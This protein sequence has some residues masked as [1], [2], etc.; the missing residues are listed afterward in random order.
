MRP[1]RIFLLI[2]VS[3]L[4][5]LAGVVRPPDGP[6]TPA[7][8]ATGCADV[9]GDGIVHLIDGVMVANY[10]GTAAGSAPAQV[11]INKTGANIDLADVV[12]IASALDTTTGCQ[13]SGLANFNLSGGALA[14][15]ANG[16]V[17]T[18]GDPVQTTRTVT[19]NNFD[20]S[21]QLTST[22]G[23]GIAGFQTRLHWDEAL[24]DFVPNT[25]GRNEAWQENTGLTTA[26]NQVLG[27]ADDGAGNEA[28]VELMAQ[29]I[30][31]PNNTF[32]GPIAQFEFACHANGTANVTLETTS[33]HTSL[34]AK[35]N[36]QYL[37]TTANATITCGMP[38]LPAVDLGALTPPAPTKIAF[39]SDR[40]GNSEI[41]VMNEDG[42]GQT[43]LTNHPAQD[44]EPSWSPD[45]S[46]IAF[47]SDRDGDNEIFVMNVDGGGLKQLTDNAF[48]ELDA[49]WSPGGAQIAFISNSDGEFDVYKMNADGTAVTQLT[50]V[51]AAD[52]DPSWS[53]LGNRIAFTSTRDGGDGDIFV[54]DVDGTDQTAV[55]ANSSVEGEAE[56]SPTASRLA[57]HRTA[58]LTRDIIAMNAD[59]LDE[60]NLTPPT[61]SDQDSS[62]SWSPDGSTLAF[63]S[64]RDG[65]PG[66]TAEIYVMNSDGTAPTRL[67]TRIGTE[68]GNA[69][70]AWQPNPVADSSTP[71]PDVTYAGD[72]PSDASEFSM[73]VASGDVNGDGVDDLIIGDPVTNSLDGQLSVVYGSTALGTGAPA[74][75]DLF[76]AKPNVVITAPDGGANE[77]LGT[78]LAAGDV[79]G[80]GIDDIVATGNHSG[81]GRAFVIFGQNDWP[82][83]IDLLSPPGAVEVRTI[84]AVDSADSMVAVAVG[85]VGGPDAK[86][87]IVLGANSADG[88]ANGR[89]RAGEAYVIYGSASLR[90]TATM[91][92]SAA[93]YTVIG[94]DPLDRL[95]WFVGVSGSISSDSTNELYLGAL[96]ADGG[97]APVP[98]RDAAGEAYAIFG[99]ITG[100]P[101]TQDLSSTPADVIVVGGDVNDQLFAAGGGATNKVLGAISANAA[102]PANTEA[103]SG[104]LFLKQGP[105]SSGTVLDAGSSSST[106][107]VFGADAG[108]QLSPNAP[109]DLNNDGQQDIIISALTGDGPGFPP[110]PRADAGEANV[111]Y[112]AAGSLTTGTIDFGAAPPYV[113]PSQRIY[114]AAAGDHFGYRQTSGDLNGDG[115]ADLIVAAPDAEHGARTNPGKVYVFLSDSPTL[116]LDAVPGGDV[117]TTRNVHSGETFSVTYRIE[118]VPALVG[119]SSFDVQL[120][121]NNTFLEGL[122]VTPGGFFNVSGVGYN[123]S[124]QSIGA[125]TARL[126]CAYAGPAPVPGPAGQGDLITLTF[127]ARSTAVSS[128]SI[129]TTSA[130]LLEPAKGT[131][132]ASPGLPVATLSVELIDSVAGGGAGCDDTAASGCPAED[133]N[134]NGARGIAPGSIIVA[135]TAAHVLRRIEVE[136]V[137]EPTSFR[138]A[139]DGTAGF[140]DG[141]GTTA[142]FR[143]PSGIDIDSQGNLYVA[144]ACNHRIRK[145]TPAGL[146]TTVAGGAN[147]AVA[148]GCANGGYAGDT[149]P[150]LVAELDTPRDV[151]VDG[152][153]HLYI[154]DTGNCRIARVDANT[155]EITTIAGIPEDCGFADGLVGVT[156]GSAQFAQPEGVALTPFIS[157]ARPS[158][159]LVGDTGNDRIRKVLG[160][161][162][163]TVASG[164]QEPRGIAVDATGRVFFANSGAD[165][166]ATTDNLV[167]RIDLDG[168]VTT[169]AGGGP[170][171]TEPCAALQQTLDTTSD[172]IL[173]NG[174]FAVTDEFVK[175]IFSAADAQPPGTVRPSPCT[176]GGNNSGD[177][178]A[179][180]APLLALAFLGTRRW[181]KLRV[182]R[183]RDD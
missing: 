120:S 152:A 94:K 68:F 22:A 138:L 31:E 83:T 151:A 15:D 96:L 92:A 114:G 112:G 99:P 179:M 52:S 173:A 38:N 44:A 19:Q 134:L 143:E 50:N 176:S 98:A 30:S 181:R 6:S 140:V 160:G 86:A 74:T 115:K 46:K 17:T 71:A 36:T 49:S 174:I 8:A 3:L 97:E 124:Q 37:P 135:D 91:S 175:Q 78:G 132:F 177:T 136:D 178:A 58:G 25:A 84:T 147:G 123:C 60:T 42:S 155:G 48:S 180:A 150:A 137:D 70:P 13:A 130:T 29:H 110:G 80:D 34:A 162:V 89:D 82:S 105:F 23:A 65:N 7:S 108:D 100:G 163:T 43:N 51:A 18:P 127:K 139:G 33:Y 73:T 128:T 101:T 66:E 56:W 61:G 117:D 109:I 26:S 45:G 164:L 121:Y 14:V 104:E 90:S 116:A 183:P 21:V 167:K 12:S 103:F 79:D 153:G 93:D 9:D 161:Q 59:G 53:P 119:L 88:P 27:P 141:F 10:F 87:E 2:A 129:T 81:D 63:T 145:I 165:T 125:G 133:L 64:D 28:Y 169:I 95:G 47:T 1:Q 5:A 41:Y 67:T 170:G 16:E 171:C 57:F 35:A 157:L 4:V 154:A 149:G 172:V 72:A 62:P 85:D 131:A 113:V 166:G 142:R 148:S 55:T 156:P 144:D 102:G 182:P 106:L 146:V 54:M 24:L 69:Q 77:L 158:A 32:T 126:A 122:S 39:L 75:I 11:N 118:G 76:Y 20:V 40:D 159:L 111:L 168:S 107:R